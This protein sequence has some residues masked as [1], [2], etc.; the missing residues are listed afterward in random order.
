MNHENPEKHERAPAI[1]A[2]LRSPAERR[3]AGF[4]ECSVG[5]HCLGCNGFV[6]D[7]PAAVELQKENVQDE[8]SRD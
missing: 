7:E 4:V 5:E 1:T 8:P 6:G 3:V 2:A